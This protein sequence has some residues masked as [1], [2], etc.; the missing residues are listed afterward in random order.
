MFLCYYNLQ[1]SS[2]VNSKPKTFILMGRSGC[3][4]GTQAK[5]IERLLIANDHTGKV[6][7]LETGARFRDF[8]QGNGYSNKLAKRVSDTGGRQPDFLAV[9]NWA[10]LMVEQLVGTEH[11]IIDGTPRSH[12]EALV[13]NTAMTF[14]EREMPYVIYLDVSRE[15]SKKRIIERAKQEN[16][17]DDQSEE[18]VNRRLD[19]F[20]T[21]VLSAVKYFEQANGYR[22]IHINGMQS[23]DKVAEDIQRAIV[24]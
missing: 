5:I 8:V 18:E 19:W 16:R 14:Y 7:H 22:F 6:F 20:E 1:M 9:W 10:H 12:E 23:I 2:H 11:I 17:S 21:D 13:L 24:G 3:G 4:K 15:W